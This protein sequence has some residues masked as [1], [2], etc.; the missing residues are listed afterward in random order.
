MK[1]I[2]VILLSIMMAFTLVGCG[3]KSEET[4][5]SETAEEE[6]VA[7]QTT[8][9]T[10]PMNVSSGEAEKKETVY[11]L[12]DAT[13]Q[14]TEIIVSDELKNFSA[15]TVNDKS[16][17]ADIEN[18]KGDETFTQN[19]TELTWN[20]IGNNIYYQG[21]STKQ[22]PITVKV[23]YTLDGNEISASDIV[24]KSGHV[25]I[26][27]DF[28]NNTSETVDKKSY[29]APFICLGGTILDNTHFRN[30]KL[31]NGEA[32][33]DGEHT[34]VAGYALPGVINS[35][36][37]KEKYTEKI[38][39]K[40]YFTIEADA[41]DFTMSNVFLAVS[42][43]LT[44]DVDSLDTSSF[45][46]LTDDIDELADGMQKLRDGSSELADG[47]DEL[48]DGLAELVR[49]SDTL[50]DGASEIFSNVV[51]NAAD[52]IKA[53]LIAKGIDSATAT[54]LTKDITKDN[55]SDKIN[56]IIK[57]VSGSTLQSAVLIG[58]YK[59]GNDID[60]EKAVLKSSIALVGIG[61]FE[62]VVKGKVILTLANRYS[63]GVSTEQIDDY[64]YL[65]TEYAL[66]GTFT[67]D[68]DLTDAQKT[69]IYS[70][71]TAPGK[72]AQDKAN[73][74]NTLSE[75]IETIA[76][77][78]NETQLQ[79]ASSY[80][81]SQMNDD[82]N[83]TKLIYIINNSVATSN[84]ENAKTKDDITTSG[85]GYFTTD[86]LNDV[87]SNISDSRVLT[88]ISY[89]NTL[90]GKS[91]AGESLTDSENNVLLAIASQIEEGVAAAGSGTITIPDGAQTYVTNNCPYLFKWETNKVTSDCL[92]LVMNNSQF[93]EIRGAITKLNKVG[94]FCSGLKQYTDG[95]Y[96]AY[97]GSKELKEGAIELRDGIKKFDDEGVSKL[98]DVVK[99]DLKVAL[100]NLDNLKEASKQYDIY[101]DKADGV[102][103][104][105]SFVYRIDAVESDAE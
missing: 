74:L 12:L 91:L 34:A 81:N 8:T 96:S 59:A 101:T 23:T 93:D 83:K 92:D 71:K 36:N 105:V 97:K 52:T 98:V 19:G 53:G 86:Y 16:D 9:T 11:A 51:T 62:E 102:K 57:T 40:S 103:S 77:N 58:L 87:I 41:T 3:N 94:T 64:G 72:S 66:F 85:D 39:D 46:D 15:G 75:S 22:L 50:N 45:D 54:A 73:E 5:E 90:A 80:V 44:N 4:E 60:S 17:L 26:R 31:T 24:G 47:A 35:L 65:T 13:G 95:V 99:N 32:I 104:S 18:V 43:S 79:T 88:Q 82:S 38:G 30:I 29:I 70:G 28:T 20:S 42:N 55:Y 63:M 61:Q 10:T 48:K 78:L 68:D 56:G 2:I 27:Y 1:K 69:V 33:D 21:T 76:G 100:D 84:T 14:S 6:T 25:T 49:N 7:E 89:L 67:N 37:L